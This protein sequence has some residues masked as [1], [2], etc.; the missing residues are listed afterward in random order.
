MLTCCMQ[1][2]VSSDILFK[3]SFV[4]VVF[5]TIYFI[6]PKFARRT[7]ILLVFYCQF[8]I[9]ALYIF[10]V[11]YAPGDVDLAY[12][13]IGF[14]PSFITVENVSNTSSFG[15][16]WKGIGW[17]IVVLILTSI[18]YH[19]TTV[20]HVGQISV[21][22]SFDKW[23]ITDKQSNEIKSILTKAKLIWDKIFLETELFH[24]LGTLLSYLAVFLLIFLQKEASWIGFMYLT[25]VLM[26]FSLNVIAVNTSSKSKSNKLFN[27]FVFSWYIFVFYS[28]I[29]FAVEYAYQFP[30]L[31]ALI[32]K[33]LPESDEVPGLI[34]KHQSDK[35]FEIPTYY[36]Y[37]TPRSIGLYKFQYKN[38]SLLPFTVIMILTIIQMKYFQYVKSRRNEKVKQEKE[39][40]NKP[41]VGH[42]P[43][44]EHP[45]LVEEIVETLH[46]ETL[47][48]PRGNTKDQVI[49]S[50]NV[51][52]I[53]LETFLVFKRLCVMHQPK[54]LIIFLF[55]ASSFNPNIFGLIYLVI[56]LVFAPAPVIASKIWFI[57][58]MYSGFVVM[59][60]Y[61]YQYPFFTRGLCDDTLGAIIQHQITNFGK[62]TGVC[63]WLKYIGLEDARQDPYIGNVLW[64]S[65][66]VLI[67]SL[68]QKVTFRWEKSLKARGLYEEG[69]LFLEAEIVV[70]K[71]EKIEKEEDIK[72][73][74][75]GSRRY[76]TKRGTVM[77]DRE[78]VAQMIEKEQKEE[79]NEMEKEGE[80]IKSETKHKFIKFT[81]KLLRSGKYY[82][83]HFYDDFG[84]EISL[85]M[86]MLCSLA[87]IQTIWGLIYLLVFGICFFS[88]KRSKWLSR[89]WIFLVIIVEINML[90]LFFFRLKIVQSLQFYDIVMNIPV[91]SRY[92]IVNINDAT[93]GTQYIGAIL[94]LM[95]FF[96]SLQSRIFFK[97]MYAKAQHIEISQPEKLPKRERGENVSD[98]L[99]RT[100][101]VDG[102]LIV[103]LDT[104]SLVVKNMDNGRVERIKD[105]TTEQE[106]KKWWNWMKVVVYRFFCFIVLIV[107]F[108]DA[109]IDA[110]VI[111]LVQMVLCLFYLN[112]FNRLYW[113]SVSFW[114]GIGIYYFISFFIY[115]VYQIPIVLIGDPSTWGASWVS[116]VCKLF[117]LKR[118]S[119]NTMASEIVVVCLYYLQIILFESE[120]YIHFVN[121]LHRECHE[122]TTKYKRNQ[123]Y[124][125]AQILS[126]FAEELFSEKRRDAN[127]YA[128][129]SFH[130]LNKNSDFQSFYNQKHLLKEEYEKVVHTYAKNSE[131]IEREKAIL[132]LAMSDLLDMESKEAAKAR[133]R[134]VSNVNKEEHLMKKYL[135]K[136]EKTF[137]NKMR[138]VVSILDSLEVLS[139]SK[140]TSASSTKESN[141]RRHVAMEKGQS[142]LPVDP[143]QEFTPS[144]ITKEEIQKVLK[145]ILSKIVYKERTLDLGDIFGAPVL[146]I[147]LPGEK[148]H[149]SRNDSLVN[150]ALQPHSRKS[151]SVDLETVATSLKEQ[152]PV[153]EETPKEEEKKPK[154]PL[155]FKI[156]KLLAVAFAFV[157]HYIFMLSDYFISKVQIFIGIA[158]MEEDEI[159]RK[160]KVDLD[161][162]VKEAV[163]EYIQHKEAE[164]K[165]AEQLEKQQKQASDEGDEIKLVDDDKKEKEK[166]D[167]ELSIVESEVMHQELDKLKVH[168]E[169]KKK[170]FNWVPPLLKLHKVMVVLAKLF[171]S[172]TDV[173][174]FF[175]MVVNALVA[176]T[177]F[178]MIFTF[179]AFIYAA[180]QY[181]YPHRFYWE[182][183]L[184]IAQ[185]LVAIQYSLYLVQT[186][187]PDTLKSADVLPEIS[188]LGWPSYDGILSSIVMYLFIVLSIFFHREVM[189]NRGEWKT[190]SRKKKTKK[191]EK[192]EEEGDAKAVNTEKKEEE[193]SATLTADSNQQRRDTVTS[194]DVP[195]SMIGSYDIEGILSNQD[196]KES[197]IEKRKSVKKEEPKKAVKFAEEEEPKKEEDENE[198]EKPKEKVWKRVG[199][200]FKNHFMS[201]INDQFKLGVDYF[202]VIMSVEILAF[203]YF[204]LTFSLMNGRAAEDTLGGIKSNQISGTLVL[205]LF[206][207]FVEICV[208]RVL[209]LFG[210]ILAKL[211]F[212]LLLVIAYHIAYIAVYIVISKNQNTLALVLFKILFFVKCVYLFIGCLQVRTGYPKRRFTQFF[213]RSYFYISQY[214]YIVY[215]AIP[216]VFELKTLLD[217]TFIDTTLNFYE[218][219]KMEDIYSSLYKRKCDLEYKILQAKGFGNRTFLTTKATSG[220][221]LF[222]IFAMILFFPLLFYS[223]FNP[224]L[225]Y[226][227]V[228]TVQINIGLEGFEPMYENQFYKIHPENSLESFSSFFDGKGNKLFPSYDPYF[229]M[230]NFTLASY[231]ETYW[232]ISSPSRSSMINA[233]RNETLSLN[234]RMQIRI[235]RA[236]PATQLNLDSTQTITLTNSKRRQLANMINVTT[237]EPGISISLPF[238]YNPYLLNQYSAIT[239]STL[240]EQRYLPNCTLFLTN[241]YNP[242]PNVTVPNPTG[243]VTWMMVCAQP[244]QFHSLDTYESLDTVQSGPFF[245]IQS[246]K[247]VAADSIISAISSFGVI[248][249]YTTFVLAI[250]QF[251]RMYSSN[252]VGRVFF[253]DLDNVDLILSYCQDIFKAREDKD[254]AM[255]ETLYLNLLRIYR[256]N[257]ML[258]VWTR[259]PK[260]NWI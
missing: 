192:K 143:N 158:W 164:Q 197:K 256:S 110:N 131:K 65:L 88:A 79:E 68:F 188:L 239:N 173:I 228:N 148:P 106:Q 211:I 194:V 28:I 191:S 64:S 114:R 145:S 27:V 77:L 208:E 32:G 56:V 220:F 107:M 237:P 216:F 15:E 169:L 111:K 92:I 201:L 225:T 43:R 140:Q 212:H 3:Y 206:L 147:Q 117:G 218:Y 160:Y 94:Y 45:S 215:R 199:K 55:L 95:L 62:S 25:I 129:R 69:C 73:T 132:I 44:S 18:Q 84:F 70:Q 171:F 248:T 50:K 127:R 40:Q 22:D 250:G 85:F 1:V 146:D 126:R 198:E 217:W 47:V 150:E 133:K 172:N 253:E 214:I 5:C 156:K 245:F 205:L 118:H 100:Q 119:L 52:A 113:K 138:E 258:Q 181:P 78:A 204:F 249:L 116:N 190:S 7:W 193:E 183:M 98:F 254:L 157:G 226:N 37:I 184:I 162:I 227:T 180:L 54:L 112:L 242:E 130:Q 260:K 124:R 243:L 182:I 251:V 166:D 153:V 222:V 58:A 99:K 9:L 108:I 247:I 161:E 46:E 238:T 89:G 189:R 104:T 14:N 230:Q 90:I 196:K 231:S 229:D 74:R 141:R 6:F 41:P 8:V 76:L 51:D 209:Y 80:K 177:Y 29:I 26:C 246:T 163:E 102:S 221:L 87:L 67:S 136:A 139:A 75:R 12:E 176:P 53:L 60:K 224:A 34:R 39:S 154:L 96:M 13:I 36:G 210:N 151:V 223:T 135:K 185:I 142:L 82:C 71:N 59:L 232:L 252:L 165:A 195:T 97:S 19:I 175:I 235:A 31:N 244:T 134:I 159:N 10:N 33:T 38:V 17:H 186:A 203:V 128:L 20:K 30:S 83:N 24:F 234:L 178:N 57:I 240:A 23:I 174:C 121:L 35:S 81:K 16:Y 259:D 21:E 63:T 241:S 236:G 72:R 4:S 122:R 103:R 187:L 109:A 167:S 255:E 66:L 49:F 155:G 11:W 120:D 48:T 91:F 213:T 144:S 152:P 105:F 207:F 170:P 168:P 149:H 61:S 125:A 101:K 257:E 202:V 123:G 179:S 93:S 219:L 2:I 137:Q 233:L 42:P 86:L 200:K 115:G